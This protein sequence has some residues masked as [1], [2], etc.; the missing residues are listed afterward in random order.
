MDSKPLGEWLSSRTA[1]Q[2][3]VQGRHRTLDHLYMYTAGNCLL[4]GQMSDHWEHSGPGTGNLKTDRNIK[5]NNWILQWLSIKLWHKS[6]LI[7]WPRKRNMQFQSSKLTTTLLP[8]LLIC[9][10]IKHSHLPQR[11]CTGL[12][13]YT[14]HIIEFKLQSICAC[15]NCEALCP[16][17]TH[18][19]IKG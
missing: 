5:D 10:S 3:K 14:G 12:F 17:G 18:F 16:G 19:G 11:L 1:V 4:A 13:V 8:T 2:D 9:V 6:I 15:L 7:M